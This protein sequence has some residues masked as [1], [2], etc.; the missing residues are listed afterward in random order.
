MT[1]WPV[2][3]CLIALVAALVILQPDAKLPDKPA[4]KASATEKRV[5]DPYPF[6]DCPISGAKLK[7]DSPIKL[8]DGREVRFC[9]AGC[10]DAFEKDLKSNLAKIDAKII[11]DQAPLY[12]LTTSVVTGKDLP[13]KPV[14]FVHGNR[15]VRVGEEKEKTEFLKDPAKYLALL[16]K[17]VIERQGKDYPLAA[18]LVTDES[19]EGAKPADVVIAGRLAR[20]CCK[21]CSKRLNKEPAKFIARIDA[22]RK[23]P[24]KPNVE[25]KKKG[26]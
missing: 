23:T 6:A 13:A 12:P 4:A 8:Y 22:A 26:G 19:F 17:A 24:A 14:E 21:G 9:C 18:C 15:L 5:G 16:D 11:K 10:P 7:D 1:Q 25:G 20:L 2:L 3:K